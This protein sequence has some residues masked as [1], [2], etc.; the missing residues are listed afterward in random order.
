M[1]KIW[2]EKPMDKKQIA[3]LAA[4]VYQNTFELLDQ[5]TEVDAKTAGRVATC[6]EAAFKKVMEQIYG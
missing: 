3:E 2:A 6:C 1:G 4:M 5:E